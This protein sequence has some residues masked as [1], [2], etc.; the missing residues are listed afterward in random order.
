[1]GGKG[2]ISVTANVAPRLCAEFQS[3]CATGDWTRAL[4]LQD[5]LYPLHDAMFSD[6]SPGPVKYAL[7]RV[8]PDMP[9]EVRLPITWP[10]DASRAAVARALR[11]AEHTSDIPSLMRTSEPVFCLKK[12]TPTHCIYI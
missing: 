8:R 10:S 6:C 4:E 5:R 3:A 11:S 7:S 2:C 9:G 1:M 12:Q